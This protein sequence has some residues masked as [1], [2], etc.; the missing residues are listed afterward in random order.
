M[1]AWLPMTLAGAFLIVLG[2][3]MIRSHLRTWRRHRDDS[4]SLAERELQFY[5]AQ[6]RRRM[7]TSAIIALLGVLLF[8]GDVVLPRVL[9]DEDFVEV[10][11]IFWTV[12]LCLTLWIVVL[13]WGDV[14]AIRVHSKTVL[15]RHLGKQR[16]LE[17]Q[18]TE[19][20]KR[21]SNGEA[22]SN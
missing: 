19:L 11:S 9:P 22:P 4:S 7:Q 21:H 1:K 20:K 15:N 12:V 13:A 2:V 14:T 8:V 16:E 5:F 17:E 10:F 3:L 18:L 6:Y